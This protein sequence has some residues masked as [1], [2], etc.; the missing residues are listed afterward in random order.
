M[1]EIS[2]EREC[3]NSQMIL[4]DGD[5]FEIYFHYGHDSSTIDT[6]RCLR[7]TETMV[8]YD[9]D[10]KDIYTENFFDRTSITFNGTGLIVSVN[11]SVMD[12]NNDRATYT[13][14]VDLT[15]TMT[16]TESGSIRSDPYGKQFIK[17][18]FRLTIKI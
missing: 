5:R 2:T 1:L 7:D 13:C 18:K 15:N 14:T 16:I 4:L 8:S 17:I 6:L 10:S 3:V 11:A 9:Q 12:G